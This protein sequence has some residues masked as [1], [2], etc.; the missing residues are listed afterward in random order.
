[1]P[2]MNFTSSVYY[3]PVIFSMFHACIHF[4]I[5]TIC[6]TDIWKKEQL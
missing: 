6:G 4:L 3:F 5:L 2:T 1:M